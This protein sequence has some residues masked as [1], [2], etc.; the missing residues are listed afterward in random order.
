MRDAKFNKP[1]Y[2][3]IVTIVFLIWSATFIWRTSFIG[4]DDRRHFC[5]FDD[6]MISMRYAWNLA[7]G[8]GLVWNEGVRVEGFTN[9]LMTLYMSLGTAL[10]GKGAAVL[11]V[12]LSGIGFM[13]AVAYFSMKVAEETLGDGKSGNGGFIAV[14]SFAA[15]LCYYPLAYWSLMGMERPVCWPCCCCPQRGMPSMLTTDRDS[16]RRCRF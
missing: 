3:S 16:R 15:A 12:Q 1:L 13:L 7:H 14:L 4:I 2:L 10:F 6:A 5:L 11:F 9:L 8:S